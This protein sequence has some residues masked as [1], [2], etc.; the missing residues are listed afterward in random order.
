MKLGHGSKRDEPLP[1]PI[2]FLD[3]RLNGGFPNDS[4]Q[5]Y[6]QEHLEKILRDRFHAYRHSMMLFRCF[7]WQNWAAAAIVSANI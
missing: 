5:K 2:Q 6:T 3:K 7:D 4:R 1:A